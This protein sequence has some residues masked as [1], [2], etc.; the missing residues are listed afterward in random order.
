MNDNNLTNTLVGLG[1]IG[2]G[3]IGV[4]G[5]ILAL[6]LLFAGNTTDAALFLIASAVSLG[7]LAGAILPR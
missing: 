3:V 1:L 7:L 4:L 2:S 5:F 6:F